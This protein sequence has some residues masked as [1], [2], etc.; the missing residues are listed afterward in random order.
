MMGRRWEPWE[1]ALVLKCE[2]TGKAQAAL[3]RRLGRT[4]TAL[5]VRRSR[6]GPALRTHTR[7]TPDQ[8]AAVA[9]QCRRF[10]AFCAGIGRTV[11]HTLE[12]GACLER[13]R[14]TAD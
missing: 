13:W 1:D 4:A 12:R 10:K 2:R 9:E 3:G 11:H 5:R 14:R 8:D 7:W 6:I